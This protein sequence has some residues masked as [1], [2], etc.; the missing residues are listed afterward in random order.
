MV[1]AFRDA[2]VR[3]APEAP[4]YQDLE[5][6]VFAALGASQLFPCHKPPSVAHAAALVTE[7]LRRLWADVLGTPR[8][9]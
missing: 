9:D 4:D 2:L 7:G 6:R 8:G 3:L 5:D 1:M